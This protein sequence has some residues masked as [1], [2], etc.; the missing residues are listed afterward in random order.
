MSVCGV[1]I[2][3]PRLSLNNLIVYSRQLL[4]R[5]LVMSGILNTSVAAVLLLQAQEIEPP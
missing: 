4:G 1:Y 2:R 5:N 3:M